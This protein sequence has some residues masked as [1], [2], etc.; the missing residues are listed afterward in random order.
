MLII[1][2][3]LQGMAAGG[4]MSLA[5]AAVGDLVS[6][7]ERARFQGYITATFAVATIAGPLVGGVLVDHV[8]WRWVFYVNVPVGMLALAGLAAK[9][10]A[11]RVDRP[12]QRLDLS[13]AALL[14]GGTC[15]LMLAC[16]WGGE[17]YAWDSATILALA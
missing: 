1:A 6:P 15:A 17:R 4:L 16:V 9:L 10:P 3:T 11:P 12:S 2:R 7:R 5:M 8:S 13:G 14:V